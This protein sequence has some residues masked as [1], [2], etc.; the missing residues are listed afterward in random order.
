MA[1][2]QKLSVESLKSLS[3][4]CG[5][6]SSHT[7]RELILNLN[8]AI[9]RYSSSPSTLSN[10]SIWSPHASNHRVLSVDMGL[11]NLSYSVLDMPDL[12]QIPTL[13]AWSLTSI[14]PHTPLALTQPD[15]SPAVAAQLAY[16]TFVEDIL[17]RFKPDTILLE[18]QRHRSAGGRNV[19][20]WTLKVNMFENVLYGVLTTLIN[21]GALKAQIC[22]VLPSRTKGY[23]IRNAVLSTSSDGGENM[24]SGRK[25]VKNKYA[26]SKLVKVNLVKR[27][28]EGVSFANPAACKHVVFTEST[29]PMALQFHLSSSRSSRLRKLQSGTDAETENAD[30]VGLAAGRK[31]KLDDLS[32]SL[33]QGVAFV[34]WQQHR[35]E[36]AKAVTNGADLAEFCKF[37]VDRHTPEMGMEQ[38][39]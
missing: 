27:W 25:P 30:D 35:F 23:W 29:I 4:L 24:S 2:F 11:R 34:Q 36:L 8:Q 1:S 16:T 28:T 12:E 38:L 3:R 19:L 17:P 33:L 15:F 18:R 32:D 37:M 7:K 21:Q 14:L 9:L 5:L 22:E 39:V 20:E 26:L 31:L 10:S 13:S 6:S